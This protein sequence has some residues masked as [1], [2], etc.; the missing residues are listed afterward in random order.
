[1]KPSRLLMCILLAADLLGCAEERPTRPDEAAKMPPTPISSP[2]LLGISIATGAALDTEGTVTLNLGNVDPLVADSADDVSISFLACS[3]V[4]DAIIWIYDYNSSQWRKLDVTYR[5]LPWAPPS[6]PTTSRLVSQIG[7]RVTRDFMDATGRMLLRSSFRIAITARLIQYTGDYHF[8]TIRNEHVDYASL[9]YANN[10]LYAMMGAGGVNDSIF[11]FDLEGNRRWAVECEPHWDAR[12]AFDGVHIW[13]Q[14]PSEHQLIQMDTLGN[15]IARIESNL[16]YINAFTWANGSLW[17]TGF[18][19][20]VDS[21]LAVGYVVGQ[22]RFTVHESLGFR[23]MTADSLGPIF[24]GISLDNGPGL[25]TRKVY[26]YTFQ[27]ELRDT[28]DFTA[29]MWA[30]AWDGESLWALHKG[31][32]GAPTNAKLLSRLTLE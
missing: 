15:V 27:G 17:S 6:C 25:I 29:D 32:L 30:I 11:A 23:R 12:S 1:M 28:F 8:A 13:T 4:D 18:Q 5:L 31:P 2:L 19:I 20:D 16:G 10:S 3:P 24:C 14:A 22:S 7:G 9:C 21:S 26:R